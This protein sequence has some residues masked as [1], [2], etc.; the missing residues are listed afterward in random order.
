MEFNKNFG[1]ELGG[2]S[3]STILLPSQNLLSQFE[4][5]NGTF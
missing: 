3:D 2:E 5:K 4:Q 1:V